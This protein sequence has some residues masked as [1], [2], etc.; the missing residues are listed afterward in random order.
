MIVDR[1]L[2]RARFERDASPLVLDAHTY[3]ATGIR[4]VRVDFPDIVV[5]LWWRATQSELLLHVQAEDYDYLPVCGW[6]DDADGRF[7]R[8]GEGIRLPHNG[9]FWAHSDVYGQNRAW[10]CF[11]GW[12]EFHDHPSHQGTPWM[13]YRHQ[14]RCRIPGLI[15]QLHADLNK[16]GVQIV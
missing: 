12:R 3:E 13:S 2:A 4:I 16:P 1:A 11:T 9:G 8:P 14:P 15:V 10:F 6:W 7:L 5:G